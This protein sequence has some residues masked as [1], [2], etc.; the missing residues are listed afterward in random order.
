MSG[1]VLL[2][3]SLAPPVNTYSLFGDTVIATSS[4]DESGDIL[5]GISF[6]LADNGLYLAGYR[7]FIADADQPT[8]AQDFLALAGIRVWR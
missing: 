6:T 3:F 5:A 7:Y 8:S 1:A 2:P 4:V